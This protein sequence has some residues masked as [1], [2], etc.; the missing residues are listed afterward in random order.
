MGCIKIICHLSQGFS[1]ESHFLFADKMEKSGAPK[2][3]KQKTYVHFILASLSLWGLYIDFH[4][5]ICGLTRALPL[6]PKRDTSFTRS[7]G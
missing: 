5:H 6:I 2:P 1:S 3:V 7:R 4:F